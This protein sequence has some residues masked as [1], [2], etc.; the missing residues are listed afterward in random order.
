MMLQLLISYFALLT[1]KAIQLYPFAW[2]SANVEYVNEHV[3]ELEELEGKQTIPD[4][5][6]ILFKETLTDG[7]QFF[8][9]QRRNKCAELESSFTQR[10]ID[11]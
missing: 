6:Y 10:E 1:Q 7:Q 8:P 5:R 11:E 9:F 3:T 4:R 2:L